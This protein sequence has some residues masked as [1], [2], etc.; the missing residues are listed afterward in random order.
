M[1]YRKGKKWYGRLRGRPL[2]CHH[3]PYTRNIASRCSPG[4]SGMRRW[5][6]VTTTLPVSLVGYRDDRRSQMRANISLGQCLYG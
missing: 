3:L 4:E 2:P 5:F 6:D 1:T